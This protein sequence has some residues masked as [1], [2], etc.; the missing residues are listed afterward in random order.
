VSKI[1]FPKSESWIS[2]NWLKVLNLVLDG[3]FKKTALEETMLQMTKTA[4]SLFIL[5]S[6]D[7]L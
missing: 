7:V 5:F 2:L 6:D 1:Y 3:A 4:M